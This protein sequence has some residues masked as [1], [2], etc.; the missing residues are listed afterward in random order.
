MELEILQVSLVRMCAVGRENE[1][2]LAPHDERRR[3][4]FAEQFLHRRVERQV[5][6][7]VVHDVHLHVG[8]H[9]AIEQSLVV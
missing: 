7:V 4:V 6:A 2:S 1:I 9:R 8:V 5:G 3:L